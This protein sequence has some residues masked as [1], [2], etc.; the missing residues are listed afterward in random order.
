MGGERR[1]NGGD[2]GEA[3]SAGAFLGE[4]LELLRRR[5]PEEHA[6]VT[7]CL[8]DAPGHYRVGRERLSVD[9]HAARVRVRP[10]WT[11]S[12]ARVEGAID[13]TGIVELVDGTA[14]V[15]ALLARERLTLRG[16][17]DALLQL[18]TAVRRFAGVARASGTLQRHFERYRDWVY[19]G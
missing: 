18:A 10:G 14:R 11:L 12:R 1:A 17:A 8:R 15:E 19:G 9:V 3:R 5:A 13:R 2:E 6:A 7:R 4:G 16:D